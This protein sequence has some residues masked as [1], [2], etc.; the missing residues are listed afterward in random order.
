MF[1]QLIINP[2]STRYI[3][4]FALKKTVLTM[5]ECTV[6][7][8]SQSC[9]W[10]PFS[11]KKHST[12]ICVLSTMHTIYS[13]NCIGTGKCSME[14]SGINNIFKH[15]ALNNSNI[16]YC[17]SPQFQEFQ[18]IDGSHSL[19]NSWLWLFVNYACAAETEWDTYLEIKPPVSH[20]TR[21]SVPSAKSS[22]GWWRTSTSTDCSASTS[23][24]N[25]S[26]NVFIIS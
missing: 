18:I 25:F 12:H 20:R 24:F 5:H 7:S 23:G 4:Q 11:V 6:T 15:S 9:V 19:Q 3:P 1:L 17:E 13:N 8:L 2:C 10:N 26:S 16:P 22:S 21:A 14:M